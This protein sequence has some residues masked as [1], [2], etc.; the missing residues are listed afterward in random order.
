MVPVQTMGDACKTHTHTHTHTHTQTHTHTHTHSLTHSLT[1]HLQAMEVTTRSKSE[2]DDGLLLSARSDRS[3]WE[4]QLIARQLTGDVP[5]P[6]PP[7]SSAL[8]PEAKTA[9]EHERE[10]ARQRDLAE[11]EQLFLDEATTEEADTA[12]EVARGH[13]E[14]AEQ[15]LE[16]DA[17]QD[18]LT[19]GG[20]WDPFP[21]TL[22][23][24]GT[25]G[26]AVFGKEQ[27]NGGACMPEATGGGTRDDADDAWEPFATGLQSEPVV[28]SAAPAARTASSSVVALAS[29]CPSTVSLSESAGPAPHA[30]PPWQQTEDD[31]ESELL[32]AQQHRPCRWQAAEGSTGTLATE[33]SAAAHA[34]TD[35][36]VSGAGVDGDEHEGP[37]GQAS[38]EKMNL[39]MTYG[40]LAAQQ[41]AERETLGFT[42][43]GRR[44]DLAL[45]EGGTPRRCTGEM[46]D[47]HAVMTPV[48]Q[49]ESGG[50]ISHIPQRDLE[51]RLS[52]LK[53]AARGDAGG[54]ASSELIT[55]K[56]GRQSL[57]HLDDTH[58][59][60]TLNW[61]YV[62][63]FNSAGPGKDSM[64]DADAATAV[65]HARCDDV[66]IAPKDASGATDKDDSA[67]VSL[68]GDKQGL[69][70][71]RC[72]R[73][74][75]GKV[76]CARSLFVHL[77]SFSL[78]SISF[79]LALSPS[80]CDPV[81]AAYTWTNVYRTFPRCLRRL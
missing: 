16:T 13:Q 77:L 47:A 35:E 66:S 43:V 10:R 25:D 20:S 41:E 60:P 11:L 5:P 71:G 79:A 46:G 59:T 75:G 23:E 9:V 64:A 32:P 19:T 78:P 51:M 65:A 69:V 21:D 39:T 6:A 49:P 38:H 8:D 42:Q 53:G 1:H 57:P 34:S 36:E 50:K 48:K 45:R 26:W 37:C 4:S 56:H 40:Y 76:A 52:D 80:L 68:P 12:G 14:A 72:G 28:Y 17:W 2:S 70:H 58:V 22:G 74:I 54:L 30:P 29:A 62:D 63:G 73:H 67:R 27:S 15:R 24:G 61:D 3:E 33:V 7:P 81:H 18:G 44:L 31:G 55:D